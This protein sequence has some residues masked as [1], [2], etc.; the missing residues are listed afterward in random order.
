MK[1]IYATFIILILALYVSGQTYLSV[2]FTA[3][4]MPPTGWTIDKLAGQWSIGGGNL[5]GGT[6]PEAKFT[7]IELTTTTRLI[8]PPVDLTGLTTVTLMFSHL[9]DFYTDVA[10]KCG[11]AT[12]HGGGTWTSVWELSPTANVGPETIVLNITN[13]DV[14]YSDFQI[15]FY[16]NGNLFNIDYWYIDDIFLCTPAVRDAKLATA[17]LPSYAGKGDT[18]N[19]TGRIKNLGTTPINSVDISFSVDGG[20]P[21]IYSISGINLPFGQSYDFTD[22]IPLIFDNAGNYRVTVSVANVNGAGIDDDPSNDTITKY[23]GVVPWLPEKKVFCEEATGTWCGWCIRGICYMDYMAETYPKTWLAVAVH[24]GDPMVET[25]YDNEISNIIPNFPGYPSGT[26][27]RAGTDFWDPE[28][29]ELRYQ[30]RISAISPG[31]VQIVNFNY[32]PGTRV[33]YFDVESEF[34]IDVNHELRLAAVISEDS[35]TGTSSEWDQANYYAG[36]SNG[37]MCGYESLPDPVPAANMHYDHVARAILDTP[38]GTPGS[39]PPTVL[40]GNKYSQYYTWTLPETWNYSKLHFIALLMDHT[41]GEIL[42]ANDVV[43][44]EGINDHSREISMGIFPNPVTTSTNVSFILQ[45]PA[46]VELSI[47][48]LAG[49]VVYS[50]AAKSYPAGEN[51]ITLKADNFDNGVYVVKLTIGKNTYTQKMSVIK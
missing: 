31:T 36:G 14:G 1:K 15:C 19:I 13:A 25:V 29:F 21:K 45:S 24:N 30:Q 50:E 8:S 44:W 39:L 7:Y 48:D 34:V 51:K 11:V 35:C 43:I 37:P 28:D 41:T 47:I 20:T 9:Y 40:A 46:S 38:Y 3:M 22:A 26:I 12:R 32:N 27:D 49:R 10:P 4:E 5:A 42:N 33:V 23:V 6:P 16:L 18:L 2:D 17:N